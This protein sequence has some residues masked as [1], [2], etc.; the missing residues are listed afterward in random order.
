MFYD[1]QYFLI[2]LFSKHALSLCCCVNDREFPSREVAMY[3]ALNNLNTVTLPAIT[4]LVSLLILCI[5]DL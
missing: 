2:L 5:L 4:I 1:Y 3:T